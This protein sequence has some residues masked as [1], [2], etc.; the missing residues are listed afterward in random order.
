M[1]DF[2]KNFKDVI[3]TQVE[4]DKEQLK[5]IL[6]GN[7]I[8]IVVTKGFNVITKLLS[9]VRK[10]SKS[11]STLTQQEVEYIKQTKKVLKGNLDALYIFTLLSKLKIVLNTSNLKELSV[12]G[13]NTL[14][15]N[16]EEVSEIL[17]NRMIEK[18]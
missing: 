4:T 9:T 18:R 14:I 17:E 15:E 16:L 11:T 13:R 6:E 8:Y 12:E 7:K 3:A 1:E 2:L 5:P 10:P